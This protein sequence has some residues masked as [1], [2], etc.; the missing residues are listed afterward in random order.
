MSLNE[1]KRKSKC[2]YCKDDAYVE[3]HIHYN[4]DETVLVCKKCH[5]RITSQMKNARDRRGFYLCI[6]CGRHYTSDE[7]LLCYCCRK[8]DEKEKDWF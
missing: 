7:S 4:P 2:H 3:H 1:K 5:T 6:N 8:K